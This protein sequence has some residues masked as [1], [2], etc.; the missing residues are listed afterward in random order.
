[1]L[2]PS[3]KFVFNLCLYIRYYLSLFCLKNTSFS[4]C[5][6]SELLQ[7]KFREEEKFH[8]NANGSAPQTV[9]RVNKVFYAPKFLWKGLNMN[10]DVSLVVKWVEVR[11][12]AKIRAEL[13][14]EKKIISKLNF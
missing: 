3:F 1:M 13:K 6:C 10:F 9:Q 7:L 14:T 11:F 8:R 12:K 5:S 4:F 2:L